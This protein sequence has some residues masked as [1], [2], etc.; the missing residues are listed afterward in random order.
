MQCRNL[1]GLCGVLLAASGCGD[2]RGVAGPEALRQK[3]GWDKPLATGMYQPDVVCSP[4]TVAHGGTVTCSFVNGTPLSTPSWTYLTSTG[5]WVPGPVN[6]ADWS[7]PM[8]ISGQVRV[9][10]FDETTYGPG[11]TLVEDITVQRRN[12]T[13]V[14]FVGGRVGTPGEIDGCFADNF[15]AFGLTASSACVQSTAGRLFI[16]DTVRNGNGYVAASIPTGV[17]N[18]PNQGIWYVDT[19]TARMDLRTQITKKFRADGDTFPMTGSTVVTA[20]CAAAFPGSPTSGRNHRTVNRNCVP[21]ADFLT[22]SVCT[23]SH[24]AKHLDSASTS[25]KRSANN[26][27]LL[28]EPTIASSATALQNQLGSLYGNANQRVFINADSAHLAMTLDTL[29]FYWRRFT[30]NGWELTTYFTRC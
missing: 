30:Q 25:A 28:F 21:T 11:Q 7:G 12:W 19:V 6:A 9:N 10:W 2:N 16:P 15:L 3:W 23:W 8:V 1:V 22:D 17:A 13:W 5:Q 14:S 4:T 26:V 20:G 18:G 24:E 27:Y 29:A